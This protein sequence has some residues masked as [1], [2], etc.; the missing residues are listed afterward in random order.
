MKQSLFT[1]LFT[2]MS[3]HSSLMAT[4]DLAPRTIT[5][6][7]EA[8]VR[9]APDQVL[10]T[11]GVE[12]RHKDLSEV[13]RMNDQ[14]VREIISALTSM[15]VANKDVQTDYLN[16][17]PEYEQSSWQRTF[18]GYVQKNT[19]VV[20]LRDISKF[21]PLIS[22]AL[23][24]GAEYIHGIDFRSSELRKHR[25]EARSLAM[26]AAKEKAIALASELGEKVGKPRLIQEGPGGYW[27]SYGGWW[28]RGYQN[29]SQNVVQDASAMRASDDAPVAPG[30]LSIRAN[31]TITFALEP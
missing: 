17:Q 25:D 4:E 5:V 7:G 9:V 16:L 27:S 3:F 15:G 22:S 29:M 26:K 12:T 23:R 6:S 10:V 1:L 20:T 13:K 28:N 18:V 19:I 30:A 2:A 31:V 11:L 14:R 21:D 8:E 24:A